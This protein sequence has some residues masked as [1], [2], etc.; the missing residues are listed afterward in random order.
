M[1][2]AVLLFRNQIAGET[3]AASQAKEYLASF[4]APA[5]AGQNI[6]PTAA[7]DAHTTHCHVAITIRLKTAMFVAS[8]L[9]PALLLSSTEVTTIRFQQYVWSMSQSGLLS[10]P[11][12]GV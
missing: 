3:F 10:S 11:M 7:I 9:D 1:E 6:K 4:E 12:S 2:I 8:L 5:L